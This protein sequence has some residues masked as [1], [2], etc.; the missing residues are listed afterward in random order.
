[1]VFPTNLRWAIAVAV[2]V[3]YLIIVLLAEDLLPEKWLIDTGKIYDT[4]EAGFYGEARSTDNSFVA[5]ARF[6]GV[7]P[8]VLNYIWIY[9]LGV[10]IAFWSIL[11]ARS[12]WFTTGMVLLIAPILFLCLIAPTKD[13]IV[14]LVTVIVGLSAY[15]LSSRGHLLLL[16]ALYVVY[17][18]FVRDYFLAILVVFLGLAWFY[19]LRRRHQVTIV[20]VAL[21]VCLVMPGEIAYMLQSQR[22]QANAF[23]RVVGSVNRTAFDNALP[24]TSGIAFLVNYVNATVRLTLPFLFTP[25]ANEA[26]FAV[27]LFVAISIY[28]RRMQWTNLRDDYPVTDEGS[29]WRIH[30]MEQLF[31]AHVL[32]LFL[33]EPDIGSYFRHIS[34]AFPYLVCMLHFLEVERQGWVKAHADA[35]LQKAGHHAN[36]GTLSPLS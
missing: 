34:A 27:V 30:R 36:M 33:F 19:Q 22:D 35:H 10:F 32:V 28:R 14:V 5:T 16:M 11:G 17:G 9:A 8:M 4:L 31:F 20:L 21:L 1:M 7:L 6:F 2:A 29:V 26:Y 23:A 12:A 25:S 24:P 3:G 13:V 15:R 18:A